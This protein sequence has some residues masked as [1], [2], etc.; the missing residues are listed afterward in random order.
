MIGSNE[1]FYK[2]SEVEGKSNIG[3]IKMGYRFGYIK[4]NKFVE[5]Y[6]IHWLTYMEYD[7]INLEVLKDGF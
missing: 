7:K 3:V 2:E 1:F 4:D 6:S 5:L